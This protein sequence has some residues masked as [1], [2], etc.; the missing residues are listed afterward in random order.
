M[1]DIIKVDSKEKSTS[2]RLSETA[3]KALES[4]ASGKETHEQILLRLIKIAK[5]MS[6]DYGSKVIDRKN[7]IG[8]KYERVHKTFNMEIG[9]QR[10]SVVCVYNDLTLFAHL[11]INKQ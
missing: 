9:K 1:S 6:K 7:V 8:T 2:I 10:Y 3:K 11:R 5:T 4:L